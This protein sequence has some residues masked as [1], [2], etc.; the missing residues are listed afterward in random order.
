[1]HDGRK[2]QSFARARHRYIEKAALLLDMKIAL[3]HFFLHQRFR[4]LQ[5]AAARH[6]RESPS[7]QPQHEH[8]I[9]FQ[10]LGGMHGHQLDRIAPLL[11][12][13]DLPAGLYEVIEILHEFRQPRGLTFQLPLEHEMTQ[14]VDIAPFGRRHHGMKFQPF[15]ERAK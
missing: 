4:K 7:G 11:L 12:E 6:H 8:M 5:H 10:P 15:G 1:M 3:G 13:I 2:R 9:E 14:P